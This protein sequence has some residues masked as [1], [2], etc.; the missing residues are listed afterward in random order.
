MVYNKEK[1]E[2]DFMARRNKVQKAIVFTLV[3][4]AVIL[5]VMLFLGNGVEHIE[6]TNGAEDFSITTI[7]DEQ[8]LAINCESVGMG[9]KSSIFSGDTVT[10]YS[11]KFTGVYEL[12]YTEVLAS[13]GMSITV[14]HAEV[15]AGN[16]R[17]VVIMEGEIIHDFALNELTQ[18][19]LIENPKG[20]VSLRIV[21]ES[22][23]F[24]L[25]Y[26]VD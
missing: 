22:A 17:I 12:Y 4:A 20:R 21:G 11:N 3:A 2:V 14:N 9:K 13:T 24:E 25:D 6:D 19:Y 16:A 18:T 10:Y 26:S 5:V 1:T 23:A 7:T 15:T 8:I